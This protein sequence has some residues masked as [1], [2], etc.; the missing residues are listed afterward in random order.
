MRWPWRTVT[1]KI[2]PSLLICTQKSQF[3]DQDLSNT[4]F[5]SSIKKF[6]LNQVTFLTLSNFL[7]H[8]KCLV[9]ILGQCTWH[10]WEKKFTRFYSLFFVQDSILSHEAPFCIALSNIALHRVKCSWRIWADCI[11]GRSKIILFQEQPFLGVARSG[12]FNF[13]LHAVLDGCSEE[14]DLCFRK[15]TYKI[16]IM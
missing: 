13:F 16:K 8:D 9:W 1:G 4:W 14:R 5:Y 15:I 11:L 12:T 6:A 2:L 7:I 10:I 3:S